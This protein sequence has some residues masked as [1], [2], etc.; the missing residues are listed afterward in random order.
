MNFIPRPLWILSALA[1]VLSFSPSCSASIDE[2]VPD[3]QTLAKLELRAQQAKPREQCFF[4]AELLHTTTVLAGRQM[5]DGKNEDALATLK[6]VRHYAEL[7]HLGLAD[8]PKRLKGIEM[9]TQDTSYRLKEYLRSASDG[10]RD[11]L[12]NALVQ[13]NRIHDE[14]LAQLFQR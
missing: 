10:D 7:V 11:L 4:Y 14:L 5:L 1:L 6:K 8:D 12:Q 13:L 2:S 3:A 9:L